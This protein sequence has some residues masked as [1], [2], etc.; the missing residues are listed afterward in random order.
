MNFSNDKINSLEAAYK[1]LQQ[2]ED[3]A[4]YDFDI[5]T[6]ITEILHEIDF[7]RAERLRV[8][9]DHYLP[10]T[11][12]CEHIEPFRYRVRYNSN[13]LSVIDDNLAVYTVYKH[14]DDKHIDF[15]LLDN[16][17]LGCGK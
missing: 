11:A 12:Q 6:A 16:V 8:I 4:M 1:A 13:T 14:G 3:E 5:E 7:E 17:L 10:L 9:L 15:D 2:I